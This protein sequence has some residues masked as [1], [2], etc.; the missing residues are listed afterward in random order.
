MNDNF[1]RT[2]DRLWCR[3]PKE[4]DGDG[5]NYRSVLTWAFDNA[6]C[7]KNDGVSYW[8]SLNELIIYNVLE[9]N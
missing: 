6:I 3:V 2:C 9:S 1:R 5:L 4:D 7:D 8:I